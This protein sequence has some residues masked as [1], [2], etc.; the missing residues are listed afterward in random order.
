[1]R[2]LGDA[3]ATVVLLREQRQLSVCQT[4]GTVGICVRY[5]L[6]MGRRGT[7]LTGKPDSRRPTRCLKKKATRQPRLSDLP[8]ESDLP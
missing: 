6:M 1:M 2:N 3:A 7:P 4:P 5:V 8:V